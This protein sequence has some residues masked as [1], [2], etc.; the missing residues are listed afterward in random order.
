MLVED[1]SKDIYTT[2]S[3]YHYESNRIQHGM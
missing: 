1:S 3:Q 2:L